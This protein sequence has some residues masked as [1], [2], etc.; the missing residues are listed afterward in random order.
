MTSGEWRD[1]AACKNHGT[2]GFFPTTGERIDP[3]IRA[4]CASCPVMLHCREYAIGNH[5]QF[6]IW[7]NFSNRQR[8]KEVLLRRHHLPDMVSDRAF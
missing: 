4:L 6:G 3:V 2:D 5:E 1:L 7:G 8:R